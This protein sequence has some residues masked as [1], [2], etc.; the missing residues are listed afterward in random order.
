MAAFSHLRAHAF[1][2]RL[3]LDVG[4]ARIC[5]ACLSF[6]SI[7][8]AEGDAREALGW[9]RRMTP[10][11]WHEGLAEYALATVRTARDA[12]IR[13]APAALVDLELNGQDS[14]IARALVTALAADL[15]RRTRTEMRLE[16]AARPRLELADPALN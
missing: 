15:T 2:K 9:A 4:A 5:Y 10:D 11:L 8:L 14:A 7:P 6:V 3:E 13:D 1:V 16:A 12:G